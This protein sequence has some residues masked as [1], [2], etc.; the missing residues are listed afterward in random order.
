M[1]NYYLMNKNDILAKIV[2][3]NN[4]FSIDQLYNNRLTKVFYDINNWITKRPVI[5]GRKNLLEMAKIAQ[6]DSCEEFVD[7]TKAISITDTFWINSE[8]NP[9]TWDK[10]SPYSNSISR[11]IANIALDG[12]GQFSNQNLASPSPQYKLGGSVDKCVK[13]VDGRLLL[14]KSCGDI[15][16]GLEVNKVRPYSEYFATQFINMVGIN[17]N[18]VKYSIYEKITQKNTIMP[19]CICEIFTNEQYGLIEYCDSIYANTGLDELFKYYLSIKSSNA[20]ILRSMMI[21]DSI[22]LNPDR[23]SGNTGFIVNNDT[24]EIK[25]LAPIYDNDCSLGALTSITSQSFEEAYDKIT[26]HMLP[27]CNLGDYDDLALIFM[28]KPWYNR[29]K[30][31]QNKVKFNKGKLIGISDNRVNFMSYLVNRRINRIVSLIEEKYHLKN[32]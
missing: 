26:K 14:Y 24:F 23:H 11:I 32:I 9:T 5:I 10:I 22:L 19:Y 13:R 8:K 30:I 4:I 28:N 16:Y 21:L 7:I 27:R 18:V 15:E 2:L 6:I 3:K 25:Q 1:R 17:K 29:L 12:L 31:L 20:N